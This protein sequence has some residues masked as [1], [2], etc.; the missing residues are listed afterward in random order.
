M[1]NNIYHHEELYRGSALM[2]TLAEKHVTICGAG[3]IGSNLMDGLCR[4][5]FTNFVVIDYD[6]IESQ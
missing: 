6:R 1:S 5:G 4:Q 3:A 2:T